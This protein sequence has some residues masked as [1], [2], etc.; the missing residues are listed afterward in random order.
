MTRER[1]TF[2]GAGHRV[3]P[4][5]REAPAAEQAAAGPIV[6][7]RFESFDWAWGGLLIFTVFLFFRPQEQIPLLRAAHLGD[8]AALLGLSAMVLLNLSRRRPITRVTPELIGIVLMGAVILATVP[9][10]FWMAGVVANFTDIYVPIALIFMLMVNALSS[11]RRIEQLCSLIVIAFG[12]V[13]ALVIIDYVRG[14]NLTEG[15]RATGPFNG[16]FQNPNDLALNVAAFLPLAM[17]NV[18]RPG[19]VSWRLLC[20][21]IS[22]LMLVVVV[23]TQSRSGAIGTVAM[24]LTFVIVA[25]LLTPVTVIASVLAGML[26]LPAVPESFWTRMASITDP[27]QDTT[28]SRAERRLLLDQAVTVFLDHPLTGVGMGQFQ[29]YDAPGLRTRWHETHNVLLQVATD[30]GILGLAVFVFL[31]L[32]AFGAAWWTRAQL[33][34]IHRTRSR[35]RGPPAAAPD[36]GLEDRERVFLQTHG[37]AMIACLAGWFVCAMFASVGYNW[38]FYYLLGLSVAARDVT[39]ARAQAYAQAAARS[40]RETA[41]A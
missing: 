18:R 1:L 11:P 2:G 19:P 6:L 25:R 41:A 27:S 16:F 5:R 26:A 7:A 9:T 13:S 12:Y 35:P 14:V 39:R 34:W 15:T 32:R 17:I 40:A 8:I 23:L 31:M 30:L 28:G 37:A 38:T 29:N 36:D 21:V 10:S 20:A 3:V 33:S 24:L 4:A 22:M